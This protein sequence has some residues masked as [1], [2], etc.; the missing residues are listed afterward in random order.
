[1]TVVNGWLVP[2]TGLMLALFRGVDRYWSLD[3]TRRSSSESTSPG[4]LGVLLEIADE[5]CHR[6]DRSQVGT[7]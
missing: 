3:E 5:M 1:M 7:A 2:R 4:S 6:S